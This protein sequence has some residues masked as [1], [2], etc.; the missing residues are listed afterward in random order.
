[1]R[2]GARGLGGHPVAPGG[3]S[4]AD[5]EKQMIGLHDAAS[6]LRAHPDY[7]LPPARLDAIAKLLDSGRFPLLDR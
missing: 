1:V 4:A 5:A 7:A 2:P 6:I 3:R